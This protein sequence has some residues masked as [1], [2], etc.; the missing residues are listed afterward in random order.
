MTSGLLGPNGQPMQQFL[1][2]KAMGRPKS[3]KPVM[4]EAFGNWAGRDLEYLNLPGGGVIQFDTSRLT[5]ADYRKMSEHYQ[6]SS[7]KDV[8][9]FMLHQLDWHIECEDKKVEEHMT[10]NMTMIWTRLVR[11]LSNAFTFGFSPNAVQ[12]EN[13]PYSGKIIISK[14]KDLRH[15]ECQVN[16][17]EVEGAAPPNTVPPKIKIFDGIRQ[18]GGQVVPVTNAFWYPLLM[19]NGDYGG[20]KLLR[21][22]FQ[23]WFFSSLIHLYQN[24]YFERF[25][26]PTPVGRAPYDDTIKVG[27]ETVSGADLMMQMMSMVKNR[28]AIVLPNDTTEQKNG[29]DKYDYTLE[30]LESQ[31]RGADFERYLTR[32]DEEMSLALFTPLLLLRTADSGGFNQG[33]AHTQVYLWMLN[34]IAGDWKEYIDRY[35][36]KPLALYNFGPRA[37]IPTIHFRKLGTAQQETLRAIVQTLI[38]K[39]KLKPDTQELGQHI[40]LALEDIEELQSDDDEGDTGGVDDLGGDGGTGGG[41]GGGRVG[42]SDKRIGR[43]ERLKN[44][45]MKNVSNPRQTTKQM[46]ERVQQQVRKAYKDGTFDQGFTCSLGF[47]KQLRDGFESVGYADADAAATGFADEASA[48]IA[49]MAGLGTSEYTTPESFIEDVDKLLDAVIDKYLDSGE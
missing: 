23:P 45:D 28:S 2:P 44:D 34:A 17:R 18:V 33:V 25:G 26:E 47:G 1:A 46:A 49:D 37:K 5:L 12:Y 6:I 32:L 8:L 39:G 11:S 27:S 38:Q 29:T 4:G 21:T 31:M 20:R 35:I 41:T 36:L 42:R 9:T 30:Y 24:R 7:S 15:E 22:A 14:I 10:Y 43:P 16:W 3:V 19:E 13:D 40:G 48:G